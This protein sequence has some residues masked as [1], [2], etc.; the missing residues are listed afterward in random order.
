MRFHNI[1]TNAKVSKVDVSTVDSGHMCVIRARS[2]S[3]VYSHKIDD[4]YTVRIA[5]GTKYAKSHLLS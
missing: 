5:F 3:T 4:L 1:V 2:N